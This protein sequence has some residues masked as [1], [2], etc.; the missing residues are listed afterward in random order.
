MWVAFPLLCAAAGLLGL[1]ACGATDAS[2]SSLGT[3]RG[4]RGEGASP[5]GSVPRGRDRG[6]ATRP[7]RPGTEASAGGTRG[8]AGEGAG[9]GG[10]GRGRGAG[11]AARCLSAP[12][13][14][15]G[16]WRGLCQRAQG[17]SSLSRS[18]WGSPGAPRGSVGWPAALR[19]VCT[20]DVRSAR[21]RIRPPR[22]PP[23]QRPR[24]LR[25][26]LAPLTLLGLRA[27]ARAG[28][29]ALRP[30]YPAAAHLS[31]PPPGL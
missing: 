14:P 23:A 22:A 31:P 5:G 30:P 11:G 9:A 25:A 20:P 7:A 28:G 24:R 6:R 2:A 16:L 3:G 18:P 15:R 27:P 10:R 1:P 26:A 13:G 4:R 21:S 8:R 19:R 29:P 12:R 17:L